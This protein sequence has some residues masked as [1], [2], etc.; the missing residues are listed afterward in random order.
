MSVP[1][2]AVPELPAEFQFDAGA[3][4]FLQFADGSDGVYEDFCPYATEAE[5]IEGTGPLP[6][7][8][9][10]DVDPATTAPPTSTPEPQ[11]NVEGV[12]SCPMDDAL[13]GNGATPPA[14]PT[15]VDLPDGLAL[16]SIGFISVA[17]PSGWD[18][19]GT[20]YANGS[21]S[22]SVFPP[23]QPDPRE[24]TEAGSLQA[25]TASSGGRW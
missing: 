8:P 13:D 18:C 12:I 25:I 11:R 2:E 3:S 22:I 6:R 19:H 23:G 4:M 14:P 21:S 20:S 24:A 15:E 16:Y 17:G 9:Q 7:F 1:L 5:A 10:A